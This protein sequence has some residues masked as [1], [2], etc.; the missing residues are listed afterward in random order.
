MWPLHEALRGKKA[1]DV[2]SW[3][4]GRVLA[5]EDARAAVASAALLAHPLAATPDALIPPTLRWVGV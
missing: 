5:F 3:S 1:G 4:P 2:V